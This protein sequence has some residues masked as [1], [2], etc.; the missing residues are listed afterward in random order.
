MHPEHREESMYNPDYRRMRGRLSE[1]CRLHRANPWTQSADATA[2]CRQAGSGRTCRETPPG[3]A[4]MLGDTPFGTPVLT[5]RCATAPSHLASD[6]VAV[7]P[8]GR[9]GRSELHAR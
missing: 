3:L 9:W 8:A 2:R 6:R 4:V 5:P 7:R 1:F